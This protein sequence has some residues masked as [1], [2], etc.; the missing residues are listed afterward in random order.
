MGRH[1]SFLTCPTIRGSCMLAKL[2]TALGWYVQPLSTSPFLQLRAKPS[3]GARQQRTASSDRKQPSGRLLG[4]AHRHSSL[5]PVI[6]AGYSHLSVPPHALFNDKRVAMRSSRSPE[7][8]RCGGNT[9]CVR[10]S[11]ARNA[12]RRTACGRSSSPPSSR[13]QLS[14]VSRSASRGGSPRSDAATAA[15][16]ASAIALHTSRLGR[17]KIRHHFFH[18]PGPAERAAC[19]AR[20]LLRRRA[21]PAP[22]LFTAVRRCDGVFLKLQRVQTASPLPPSRM[23]AGRGCSPHP[24][25]HCPA[26]SQHHEKHSA[27]EGGDSKR[28]CSLRASLRRHLFCQQ[29]HPAAVAPA[30][31]TIP[32]PLRLACS[33]PCGRLE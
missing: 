5:K 12:A 13:R 33:M 8:Q 32:W 31:W 26:L 30:L 21:R 29:V 11:V 9:D 18:V 6:T 17:V 25:C 27:C 28:H 3:S 24:C 23:S 19:A 4:D 14:S 7:D 20:V 22:Q 15:R 10:H 2:D 1:P 16:F